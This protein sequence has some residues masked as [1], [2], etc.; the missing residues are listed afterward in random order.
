MYS[1]QSHAQVLTRGRNSYYITSIIYYS[2]S[3]ATSPPLLVLPFT[4]HCSMGK[5][6][7]ITKIR[8]GIHVAQRHWLDR[9]GCHANGFKE[10]ASPYIAGGDVGFGD[11]ES[12]RVVLQDD[13]MGKTVLAELCGDGAR[14]AAIDRGGIVHVVNSL[15]GPLILGTPVR[16]RRLDV[17]PK[18]SMIMKVDTEKRVVIWSAKLLTSRGYCRW[19]KRCLHQP[20][21]RRMS[22]CTTFHSMGN[23]E[24]A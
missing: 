9:H 20:R 17:R 13:V 1:V 4:N 24:A 16:T 7:G 14:F 22:F 10:Y 8:Y 18:K 6:D 5:T 21:M 3:L 2:L 12:D 11:D 23:E 19:K 15:G